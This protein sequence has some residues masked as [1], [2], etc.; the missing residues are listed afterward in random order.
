MTADCWS[1]LAL[2]AAIGTEV[3]LVGE[4]YLGDAATKASRFIDESAF[5]SRFLGRLKANPKRRR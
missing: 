1:G 5:S 3:G 2:P 4:E